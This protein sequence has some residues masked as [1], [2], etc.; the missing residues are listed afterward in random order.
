VVFIGVLLGAALSFV[1]ASATVESRKVLKA[2]AST[3]KGQVVFGQRKV[4]QRDGGC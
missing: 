3:A 2:L 1:N 4:S